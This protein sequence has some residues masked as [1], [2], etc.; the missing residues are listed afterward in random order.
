MKNISKIINYGKFSDSNNLVAEDHRPS[1]SSLNEFEGGHHW[2]D[3]LQDQSK[4][5]MKNPMTGTAGFDNLDMYEYAD[6]ING[7]KTMWIWIGS[8]DGL[9]RD[10]RSKSV[11]NMFEVNK[12]IILIPEQNN[13]SIKSGMKLKEAGEAKTGG[14]WNGKF[15][16]N[17]KILFNL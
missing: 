14:F 7:G 4:N 16:V 17:E 3:E 1:E 9:K 15:K 12:N 5:S 11:N 2:Y 8:Q 10:W 6:Y 13:I